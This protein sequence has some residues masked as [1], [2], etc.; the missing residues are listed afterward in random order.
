MSNLKYSI[1]DLK[2]QLDSG[3]VDIKN[4]LFGVLICCS[5]ITVTLFLSAAFQVYRTRANR[6]RRRRYRELRKAYSKRENSICT[7][8]GHN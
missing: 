1:D 2:S 5:L 4:Y 6:K 7:E 8:L 3:M